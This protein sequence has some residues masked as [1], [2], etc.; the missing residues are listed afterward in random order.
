MVEA[1][2]VIIYSSSS[3]MVQIIIVSLG[4]LRF[5]GVI[6]IQFM[7]AWFII[8][9]G[10]EFIYLY[11]GCLMATIWIW[12]SYFHFA[13][14]QLRFLRS[15]GLHF[16]RWL[17]VALRTR[18]DCLRLAWKLYVW[19]LIE[20]ENIKHKFVEVSEILLREKKWEVEGAK[21]AIYGL[22]FKVSK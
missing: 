4:Y 22:K 5:T 3:I 11:P 13:L 1:E 6:T 10:A 17:W 21:G 7:V 14:R 9:Y 15:T 8:V 19:Q 18:I 12:S 16:S 20:W 2:I